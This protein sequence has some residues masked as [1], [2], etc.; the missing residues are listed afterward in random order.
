MQLYLAESTSKFPGSKCIWKYFICTFSFRAEIFTI[1]AKL[2]GC[3]FQ[4]HVNTGVNSVWDLGASSD[5][6]YGVFFFTF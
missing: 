1:V 3:L 4:V 2:K 5:L 6:D